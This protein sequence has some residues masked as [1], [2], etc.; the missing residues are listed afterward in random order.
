MANEGGWIWGIVLGI[1]GTV[2]FQYITKP[3][4]DNPQAR[5]MFAFL[6]SES[7]DSE[8]LILPQT[9]RGPRNARQGWIRVNAKKPEAV[10]GTYTMQ[11][12]HVNCET[13]EMRTLSM[14]AY[15]KD[16]V[17]QWSEDTAPEKQAVKYFTPTSI[18]HSV[19]AHL[20]ATNFDAPIPPQ[21]LP[22]EVIDPPAP[23]KVTIT[24]DAKKVSPS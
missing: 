14:S 2:G 6:S 11:L 18:G 24:Q 5:P 16:G 8:W 23:P 1:A 21:A 9:V 12:W 19:V 4:K 10:A 20:C 15:N 7:D 13:T 3:D 22:Q 17:L